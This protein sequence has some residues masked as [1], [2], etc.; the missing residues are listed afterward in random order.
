M[1]SLNCVIFACFR[2]LQELDL[3]P[4]N[5][6]RENSFNGKSKGKVCPPLPTPLS[7]TTTCT[8]T[9][10]TTIH[11]VLPTIHTILPTIHTVLPTVHTLL[12][13]I[14]TVLSMIQTVL[15]TTC[16]VTS[17]TTIYTVYVCPQFKPF[18]PQVTPH[19]MTPSSPTVRQSSFGNFHT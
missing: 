9:S 7:S 13:T 6:W 11:T 19:V 10:S 15:P 1:Y 18:F 5:R 2:F 3:D 8:V 17:L 4:V 16:T 14:H 12:P